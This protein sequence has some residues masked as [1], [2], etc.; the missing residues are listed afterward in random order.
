MCSPLLAPFVLLVA[1]LVVTTPRPA[2]AEDDLEA[3][4]TKLRTWQDGELRKQLKKALAATD[5]TFAGRVL[6]E[7][8][9]ILPDVGTADERTAL[10]ALEEND[11]KSLKA[12][13]GLEKTYA[14]YAAAAAKRLA[15]LAS[16]SQENERADDA[17]SLAR[18]ATRYDPDQSEARGVLGQQKVK[19]WGW[20]E[21]QRAL[22]L[23]KGLLPLG[24]EF[25]PRA[26]VVPKRRHWE[27]AWDVESDHW[28]IRSNLELDRI[29]ELRDLLEAHYRGWM[30]DWDGY[31][32]MRV[33]PPRFRVYIF[34]TKQQYESYLQENDSGHIRNVP[35]QYSPHH[36]LATFFDVEVLRAKGQRVSSLTE[37]MLHECTHQLMHEKL[38]GHFAH[39]DTPSSP[40]FWLHEG[41]CEYYGMHTL[42]KGRL[43]LDR[44]AIRKMVR[45][46]FLRK[47]L[48]RAPAASDLIALT[49]Q[50][51]QSA[52]GETRQMNY[53]V[54]GFLCM[55]LTEE[56]RSGFRK[57]LRAAYCE[58]NT[59]DLVEKLMGTDPA[60][61]DRSLRSFLAK[62]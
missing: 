6:N 28:H 43:V 14:K 10:E 51:Y 48:A 21:T 45:T 18:E 53:V 4:L 39:F 16:W 33:N 49:R 55:H 57:L 30:S 40:N 29:F 1:S 5:V 15:A 31:L 37:L 46:G 23:R 19:G 52:D 27:H 59:P 3:R 26:K 12:R 36:K 47:R 9:R 24:D 20:V 54:S 58:E 61:L 25:L 32:P 42:Q 17:A 35:G 50:A 60:E 34:A 13:P 2:C 56:H 22:R 11:R 62:L 7:L 38:D 44:K 41:L 8:D